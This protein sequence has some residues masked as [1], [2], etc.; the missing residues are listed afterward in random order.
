MKKVNVCALLLAL[1]IPLAVGVLSAVLSMRGMAAYCDMEK[2]PLSPPAWV[3]PVAWTILYLLMGW[4]AY[5]VYVADADKDQKF[6]AL[7]FFAFQ[8]ILNFMWT[9]IFFNWGAYLFAFIWL[10]LL[11][12]AVVICVLRFFD[13]NKLAAC[14]MIPYIIWLGFAAY[15]NVGVYLIDRK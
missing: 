5:L 10:L 9:I 12:T 1:I 6:V 8:L 15:L 2:P 14:L 4:S 13:I 11:L 7:A 3:F